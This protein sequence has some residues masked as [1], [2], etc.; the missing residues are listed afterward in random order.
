MAASQLLAAL[1][2]RA[3]RQFPSTGKSRWRRQRERAGVQ[4][5]QGKM[6]RTADVEISFTRLKIY[7]LKPA[8]KPAV[9]RPTT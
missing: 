4:A 7:S 5:G 9:A 1:H 8:L 2:A 6:L 3:M